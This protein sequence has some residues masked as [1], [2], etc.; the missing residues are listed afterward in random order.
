MLPHFASESSSKDSSSSSSSSSA[1]SSSSEPADNV[2]SAANEN[3]NS[4]FQVCHSKFKF[5]R[6]I[7]ILFSCITRRSPRPPPPPTTP[8]RSS[9]WERSWRRRRRGR[10]NCCCLELEI[11]NPAQYFHI[12]TKVSA[13]DPRGC[14]L[15]SKMF[16][17]LIM[18]RKEWT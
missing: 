6:Q 8:Y 5:W 7:Q 4:P 15:E 2:V 3:A 17:L 10:P 12:R 13:T 11:E 18:C 16:Q 9:P 14:H 1:A